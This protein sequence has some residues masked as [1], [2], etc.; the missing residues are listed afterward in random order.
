MSREAL[1]HS[2]KETPDLQ[3]FVQVVE[4]FRAPTLK[5][6]IM[7]VETTFLFAKT[8]VERLSLVGSNREKYRT[9]GILS[10]GKTGQSDYLVLGQVGDIQSDPNR[11]ATDKIR[12]YTNVVL[13]KIAAL[14]ENPGY[15]SSKENASVDP[16]SQLVTEGI[17]VPGGA[18][19]YGKVKD[20]VFGF[21]GFATPEEDDCVCLATSVIM[22]KL[23]INQALELARLTG[24]TIYPQIA[25]YLLGLESEIPQLQK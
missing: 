15:L 13:G 21:S 12:K 9:G 17:V 3:H 4:N 24:N 20:V 8:V 16:K 23:E 22:G 1:S 25:E 14:L 5:E 7:D 18:M 19:R 6:D 11:T 10:I 2:L